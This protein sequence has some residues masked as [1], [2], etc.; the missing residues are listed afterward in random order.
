MKIK[1]RHNSIL[2]PINW[3]PGIEYDEY[4]DEDDEEYIPIDEEDD[5]YDEEEHD[6]IDQEEINELMAEPK[7]INQENE[8]ANTNTPIIETVKNEDEDGIIEEDD[9]DDKEED[10]SDE[11]EEIE[12]KVRLQHI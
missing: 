4:Q 12:R 9:K 5:K 8:N 1:G 10:S 2:Y 6:H 11:E 7:G 3:R